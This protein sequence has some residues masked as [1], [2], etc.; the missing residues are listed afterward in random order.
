MSYGSV[1]VCR[2]KGVKRGSLRNKT[3]PFAPISV[4]TESSRCLE[5]MNEICSNC[6]TCNCSR[7]L[8]LPIASKI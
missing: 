1:F 6:M 4:T 7:D 5:F 8:M 2:E 3:T